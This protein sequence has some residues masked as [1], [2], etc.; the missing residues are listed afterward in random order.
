MISWPRVICGFKHALSAFGR[1]NDFV[2]LGCA[3]TAAVVGVLDRV[4]LAR[5]SQ[6]RPRCCFS[7]RGHSAVSSTVS[8]M[9][10]ALYRARQPLWGALVV[11]R[12]RVFCACWHS[13]FRRAALECTDASTHGWVFYSCFGI[14]IYDS[15]SFHDL[16]GHGIILYNKAIRHMYKPSRPHTPHVQ[17][18]RGPRRG[19]PSTRN[20]RAPDQGSHEA[21]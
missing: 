3:V 12:G 15:M 8:S 13:R 10:P 14:V 19:R 9:R 6:R 18:A 20:P 2:L 7:G 4:S 5:G 11:L 16:H 17:R 21:L 1:G